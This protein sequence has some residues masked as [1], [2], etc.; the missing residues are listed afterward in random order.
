MLDTASGKFASDEGADD[1][2]DNVWH[3]L[4]GGEVTGQEERWVEDDQRRAICGRRSRFKSAGKVK[5]EGRVEVEG[6][7][8]FGA[9]AALVISCK[10]AVVASGIQ[11][12]E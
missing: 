5:V 11:P 10:G 4:A 7:G 8:W 12:D 2:S 3:V 6:R 1:L 9:Q